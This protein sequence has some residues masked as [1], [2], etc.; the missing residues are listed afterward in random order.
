MTSAGRHRKS[1]KIAG[2]TN[3]GMRRPSPHQAPGQLACPA[4]G[5]D[6]ARCPP[7]RSSADTL[8]GAIASLEAVRIKSPTRSRKTENTVGDQSKGS[9]TSALSTLA[10][11][12]KP[13]VCVLN[14]SSILVSLQA[15]M[16]TRMQHPPHDRPFSPCTGFHPISGN[17]AMR[18][19]RASTGN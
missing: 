10:I 13:N 9:S 12:G 1:W 5:L 7:M 14:A 2:R 11:T 17:T 8:K 6:R 15:P 18:M 16:V 4:L 19:S 3:G